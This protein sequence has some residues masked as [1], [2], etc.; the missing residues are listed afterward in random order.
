M[1]DGTLVETNFSARSMPRLTRSTFRL[2]ALR[3]PRRNISR[4]R[5]LSRDYGSDVFVS[6]RAPSPIP[7]R[8]T[9]PENRLRIRHDR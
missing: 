7:Q 8:K 6:E 3:C 1:E 5:Q 9:D 4:A 2:G